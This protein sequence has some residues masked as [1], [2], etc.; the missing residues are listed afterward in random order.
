MKGHSFDEFVQATLRD[1]GVPDA[2]VAISNAAGLT[3]LKGCGIRRQG[4]TGAVDENTRFQIASMSKFIT[5]TAVG[6][7][8]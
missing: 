7:L 6:V 3:F 1:Y 2:V 4:A 5:A 8:V